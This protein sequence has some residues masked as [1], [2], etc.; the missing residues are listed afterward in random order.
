MLLYYRHR[1]TKYV[2]L[3]KYE[4]A[5]AFIQ[6][7]QHLTLFVDLAEFPC[8]YQFLDD[9]IMKLFCF[10]L[11]FYDQIMQELVKTRKFSEINKQFDVMGWFN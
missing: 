10:D 5:P 3:N 7:N 1:R 4:T 6:L 11:Q 9:V 2:Q 8:F